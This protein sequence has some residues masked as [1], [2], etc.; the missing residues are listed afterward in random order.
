MVMEGEWGGLH[1]HQDGKVDGSL[2]QGVTSHIV[3]RVV[4]EMFSPFSVE[5]F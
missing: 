5:T 1:D 2:T 4:L 3:S